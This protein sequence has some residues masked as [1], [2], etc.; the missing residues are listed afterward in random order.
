MKNKLCRTTLNKEFNDSR[1][2]KLYEDFQNLLRFYYYNLNSKRS[3]LVL[4]ISNL[5]DLTTL[6]RL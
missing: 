5:G 6:D 2:Y 1:C 4:G 3:F